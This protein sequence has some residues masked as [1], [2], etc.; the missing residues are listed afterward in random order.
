MKSFVLFSVLVL[1]GC[2]SVTEVTP[3]GNNTYMV[4]SKVAGGHKSH[5][6][7]KSLALQRA[8]EF[9]QESGKS[10]DCFCID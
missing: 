6:E 10:M 3:M 5:T 4:G 9:C 8:N 7:V 2:A 1:S